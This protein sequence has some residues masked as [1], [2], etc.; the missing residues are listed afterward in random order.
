MKLDFNCMRDIMLTLETAL[1]PDDNGMI[2][3]ISPSDLWS[4]M[5][6]KGY[7]K[8]II[9]K[10]LEYLIMSGALIKGSKWINEDI[11]NV[12]DIAY[13]EGYSLIENLREPDIIERLYKLALIGLPDK[14]SDIVKELN[15]KKSDRL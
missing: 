9:I 13:P 7:S 2:D 1:Q 4:L 14:V 6:D 3:E 11:D 8:G 5:S 12:A 10:H 15:Q